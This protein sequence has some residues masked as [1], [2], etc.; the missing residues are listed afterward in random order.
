MHSDPIQELSQ[1]LESA[2]GL[3]VVGAAVGLEDHRRLLAGNA[4]RVRESQRAMARAAGMEDVLEDSGEPDE[5]GD[6]LVTGDITIHGG[7]QA[8]AANIV[9]VLKGKAVEQQV[10]SPPV[11]PGSA[12][13][14]TSKL[15]TCGKAALIA[16]AIGSGPLTAIVM[17]YLNQP[18]AVAPADPVVM[19]NFDAGF[20]PYT[21]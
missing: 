9:K 2:A 10:D 4:K 17:H 6:I 16:A 19:P 21:P 5:M 8:D 15:A 14:A 12:T 7:T 3:K 13:P 18:A 20:V 1:L 11:A